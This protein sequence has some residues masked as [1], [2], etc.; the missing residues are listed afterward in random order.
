M[1]KAQSIAHL[2]TPGHFAVTGS[3]QV[4]DNAEGVRSFKPRFAVDAE[5]VR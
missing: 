3:L 4:E 5:G 2:L 1:T